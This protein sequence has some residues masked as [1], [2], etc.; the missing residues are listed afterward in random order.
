MRNKVL[1]LLGVAVITIGAIGGSAFASNVNNNFK[2]NQQI[3]IKEN[4]ND[5]NQ[6]A[7]QNGE[8]KLK[9]IAN[10]NNNKS[11]NP[12]SANNPSKD[13]YQDM[14]KIM[15]DNGFKEM[16]RY[17]Q[18]G[19]YAAMTDYMNNISQ[20]NYEIMIEIMNNNGYGQMG[21]MMESIGREGMIDMHN[22]MGSMHGEGNDMSSMH[23]GGSSMMGGFTSRSN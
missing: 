12:N 2:E 1:A 14:I 23:A 19:D 20:E 6:M 11:Y 9:D 15:R 7:F 17:M 13:I 8:L 21:Q 16:A 3:I 22:F 18:T 4:R 5:I 10:N